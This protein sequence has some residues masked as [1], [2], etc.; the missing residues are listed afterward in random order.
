MTNASWIWFPEGNPAVDAP[1]AK[2]WFRKN[3]VLPDGAAVARA[4]LRV[5]ADDR[6][7]ATLN[8][9]KLGGGT[10][11][12]SPRQFNDLAKDLQPGANVLAVEAEN[13]PANSANPAGLI[14]SL[15]IDLTDSNILR[16]ATDASWEST[17]SENGP[18][19]ERPDRRRLRRRPLGTHRRSRRRHP[20][21]PSHRHPLCRL[22][23][24][25]PNAPTR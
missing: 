22:S 4:R 25:R 12:A 10:D 13:M 15:E 19:A 20:R 1:A 11:W 24:L 6:F 17:A 21:P 14:A 2:R 3:F 18:W 7:T 23:P 16:V 5:S 8:G 9:H